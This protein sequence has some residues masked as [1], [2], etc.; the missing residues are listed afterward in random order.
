[1]RTCDCCNQPAILTYPHGRR[2]YCKACYDKK[3]TSI[4][5]QWAFW[6]SAII[7]F[8]GLMVG[9]ASADQSWITWNEGVKEVSFDE[10]TENWSTIECVNR[11]P[12]S[13][14]AVGMGGTMY[15]GYRENEGVIIT[16]KVTG[17][18]KRQY[19]CGK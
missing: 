2:D 6:V 14:D 17:K 4:D 10:A 8:F 15:T 3:Q 5:I 1:M 13:G 19:G 16:D 9:R 12:I 18:V 7:F 11:Y